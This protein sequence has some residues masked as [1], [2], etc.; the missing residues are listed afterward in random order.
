MEMTE[1]RALQDVTIAP[2]G[3][4]MVMREGLK[5]E[6]PSDTVDDYIRGRYVEVVEAAKPKPKRK[7]TTKGADNA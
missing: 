4:Q 7:R 5:Y 1:V 6:I 3:R 2:H